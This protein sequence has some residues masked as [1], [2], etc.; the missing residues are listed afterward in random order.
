[1]KELFRGYERAHGVF[2]IL[3]KKP[4]GKLEGK[5][6]TMAGEASEDDWKMHLSGE[7]GLGIIPLLQDNNVAFG[8]IDVDV[9]NLDHVVLEKNIQRHNFPLVM[10]RSK[11]GGAHLFLFIDGEASSDLVQDKLS[12]MAS[13][14]G[15]G[16]AEIFPKQT[17]R[18]NEQDIGN[19]LNM[20]YFDK[21]KTL[22]YCIKD[23][24]PLKYDEF[25]EYAKS[26]RITEDEL[27]S[28][29]VSMGNDSE[30]DIFRE[31]PPC[32]AQLR[33]MG[34]FPQGTRNEGMFSVGVY[35]RKRFPDTWETE[36]MSYNS[37]M[38]QPPLSLQEIQV[39]VKSLN[40]KGYEYKCKVQPLC[41]YCNS[42]LCRK[43]QFGIGVC[44]SSSNF[45]E[46]EHITKVEGDPVLWF[47][48][49]QGKRLMLTTDDL[50]SQTTFN[51]RCMEAINR[52]PGTMN[53]NRWEKYLDEQISKADVTVMP[54][55]ISEKGQLQTILDKYLMG[56]AQAKTKEELIT[57]NTP[58]FNSETGEMWFT[59][60]G[61]NEYLMNHNFKVQSR[62]YLWQLMRDLGCDNKN[63]NVNGKTRSVWWIKFDNSPRLESTNLIQT[64]EF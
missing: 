47:V 62:N 3:G 63:I 35:L 16:K 25:I 11:S 60:F 12:S 43:R 61:F 18:V 17:Y 10:C 58:Y 52:V 5:A 20:P 27:K 26:K 39:L 23:G 49:V 31:G 14:L 24:K 48:S 57:L 30:D 22:R 34:G 36:M 7:A 64:V 55:D 6:F 4:N 33:T 15:Y 38:C 41:S 21:D 9:Y 28:L 32:L 53:K 40:K 50:F 54:D 2:K 1:M 8:V 51:K 56:N 13:I 19:W 45:V 37:E 44:E 46:I 29:N 42:K 59:A